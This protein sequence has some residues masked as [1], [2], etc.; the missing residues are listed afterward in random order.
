MKVRALSL[1]ILA[2]MVFLVV[3]LS[4]SIAHAEKSFKYVFVVDDE[5]GTNVTVFFYDC[6]DGTSW[7]LIPKDQKELVG[8]AV[9][10]GELLNMTYSSLIVGGKEDPFY[11]IMEFSYKALGITNLSIRYSMRYGALIIEPSAIFISPRITHEEAQTVVVAHLPSFVE[12]SESRVSALSGYIKNVS[13]ARSDEYLTISA[14]IGSDDR[15]VVEYTVPRKSELSSVTLGSLIFKVHPRYLDFAHEI[16]DALNKAYK[17]YKEVFR[18]EPSNI[19]V[20]FFVPS[21]N[22]ILLGLMGY[23]PLVGRELG[24]I[25]LNILYIRGVRGFM[26]VVAIHELAHHF[27]WSINVPPSKLWIHEG[28]AQY[29]SLTI[30]SNLG[31]HE[32]VEI[33]RDIL[34]KGLRRLDNDLGFVQRWT[35][36]SA[37]SPQELA[38]YYAASY[39]I[40]ETLCNKYGGL[41]FLRKL[42]DAFKQLGPIDWYDDAKVIEA[43]GK[44][45]GDVDR[46]IELFREWKFEIDGSLRIIPSVPQIRDHISR[47]PFWL[48][49]YRSLAKIMVSI[50]ELLQQYDL[51]YAVIMMAKLSRLI[52]DSSLLFMIISI[53]IAVIATITLLRRIT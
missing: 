52:H 40:I 48:E 26:G 27:L 29:M 46:V 3:M 8:V 14:A 16:L 33:Y 42:F 2:I 13:V 38:R 6:E 23:V 35:P 47:M 12:T 43:F 24:P 5:G 44:A 41:D 7:L 11:V 53:A 21:T 1:T 50:A 32:A 4:P 25:H 10:E 22:D 19:Y 49:P 37:V 31:Y 45:T 30:G 39:Y 36:Y 17:I 15:L 51:F 9:Y 18:N 20:E 34:E 28:I